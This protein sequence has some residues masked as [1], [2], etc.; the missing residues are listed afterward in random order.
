MT[1]KE[2][3]KLYNLK[4]EIELNERQLVVLRKEI[5]ECKD[6]LDRLRSDIGTGGIGSPAITDMPKGPS[7]P[8]SQI[9]K[10]S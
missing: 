10:N 8:G 1:L 4:R 9:E 3:S 7:R 6:T 5:H 2:L